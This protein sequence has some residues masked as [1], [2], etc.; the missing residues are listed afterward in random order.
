MHHTLCRI[1]AMLAVLCS[2]LIGQEPDQPNTAV[3][4]LITLNGVFHP[5]IGLLGTNENAT[6]SIYKE[7]QGGLPLWQETQNVVLDA[8][9]RYTAT[10]GVAHK[11]GVPVDLFS[12]TEPR[13][14]GVQFNR[15]G[16]VEQPRYQLVSVPY[17]LKSVDAETLG[18]LPAS[19][20]LLSGAASASSG[21][22]N[23]TNPSAKTPAKLSN[24]KQPVPDVANGNANYVIGELRNRAAVSGRA[25]AT[26]G[27]TALTHTS[28]HATGSA[29]S[30]TTPVIDTTGAN[31]AVAAVA[32]WLTIAQTVTDSMGNSWVALPAYSS[33]TTYYTPMRLFYSCLTKVGVGHTFTV[34]STSAAYQ[35][36]AVR[37]YSG[38]NCSVDAQNGAGFNAT[39][40][41]FPAGS[42]TTPQAG[43]LIVSDISNWTTPAPSVNSGLT[44]QETQTYSSGNN[45]G[46][47]F[48]DLIQ[49]TAGSI[50][51]T[52][53][54]GSQ[55]ENAVAVAAFPP[56]SGP[57]LP[58]LTS[59][60]PSSG[61]Q[62]ATVNVILAGSN[63]AGG[64]INA[65]SGITIS[66]VV[67]SASQVTATF[68]IASGA[69]G[70]QNV[71]VTTSA[72]TSNAL[73]FTINGPPTSVQKISYGTT[74]LPTTALSATTCD[75]APLSV[76]ANGALASDTMTIAPASN[77]STAGY[78]VKGFTL[79]W[80]VSA[81]SVT[82]VRCNVSQSS[83][84]PSPLSLNWSVL[85]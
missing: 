34:S 20:Y 33:T 24:P 75:S 49:S 36:F 42:I 54:L 6:F 1:A 85:R 50:N 28:A 10:L 25:A 14:L 67:S 82:F 37:V 69:T 56:T 52:W 30:V 70:A 79:S 63:L 13:W 74:A 59:I 57:P 77:A 21:V 26:T 83:Q 29:L 66:N 84:S 17:A 5:A 7:Q 4:R 35:A 64:S 12:S 41:T 19:A 16:E 78:G 55:S 48:A 46:I 61:T 39:T 72:G 80:F 31:F 11:E 32:Y 45:F 27:I 40:T 71:T 22:A 73:T 76:S 51:P 68:T 58:T 18:G 65:I 3:P 43:D 53:T 60:T 81:N 2:T 23:A 62:G 38:V 8:N 15:P 47:G 44:I 9:G